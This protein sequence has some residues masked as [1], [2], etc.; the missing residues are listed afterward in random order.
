[1][2]QL[3][4]L[5][6]RPS[7]DDETFVFMLDYVDTEGKRRRVS[8]GHADKR[9]AESQQKQTERELKMGVLGRASMKLS[10]FLEDS[11]ARTQGQVRA[12]T[13]TEQ[14]TAMNQL[15]ETIGDVDLQKVQYRHGE[16]FIQ[17]CLDRG[18]RPATAY[19]KVAALK[20]L[21]QLAVRRGH[22]E[23]NPFRN[24]EHPKIA[25]QEIRIY[26]DEECQ[27]ILRAAWQMAKDD[28]LNWELLIAVGLCT[29]MRRG[30]LLNT[31]W[32]DID[33]G[34]QIIRVSPK[35][36]TETTWEWHIKDAERRTLPL[37]DDVIRLLLQ[38]QKRLP[39]TSIYVFVPPA[40]CR[41]IA[42]LRSGDKWSTD[43]GRCPVNNFNR[44]FGQIIE[45]ADIGKGEFHDLRRTCLTR[46]FANGLMEFDVMKLAGHSDFETTHKFYLAV[47]RDL[48]EKAR[49]AT[50]AAM[51]NDFGTHL[52]R[53]CCGQKG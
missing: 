37:T 3:V 12:S 51:V 40:R 30:E 17:A 32:R 14:E 35:Q 33:V 23:I 15:I 46:W 47:R 1:M 43:R 34:K 19:K 39:E 2:K 7:R 4:R 5:R 44:D 52:A 24:L 11:L 48:V 31:T 8:L 41:R 36:N 13:L 18:N 25:E 49:A 45:R 20:R 42:E 53:A 9:K 16:H 28:G 29:G 38:H 27:A 22:L 21:F 26:S 50:A 6:T 10:A